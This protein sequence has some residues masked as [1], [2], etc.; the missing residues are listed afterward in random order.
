[1][2]KR[3]GSEQIPTEP[4]VAVSVETPRNETEGREKE[5]A[6]IDI[7]STFNVWYSIIL[8]S[9]QRRKA[10]LPFSSIYP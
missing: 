3:F 10:H 7:L 5:T 4:V 6:N 8:E 1:M 2:S 9:R